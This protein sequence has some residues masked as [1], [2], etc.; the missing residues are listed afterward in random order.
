MLLLPNIDPVVD[1]KEAVE[2]I[3][4]S[5][6]AEATFLPRKALIVGET[7]FAPMV[8]YMKE[9][10]I[11]VKL[12]GI[13]PRAEPKVKALVLTFDPATGR[14]KALINGTQLTAWRTAAASGVAVLAMRV[15]P[16]TVGIIGAGLQGEYHL[17]V[18]KALYPGA[19]FKIYSRTAEKA[20]SL[21]AKYGVSVASLGETLQSDLVV[22]ATNS[23]EPV[24]KGAA[25][26]RGAAVVSVGA[27]RPV[28]EIDD[29]AKSRA[30]VVLVD[31][32]HAA[33][34]SDDVGPRWLYIGDY[35][36]GAPWEPG[37]LKIYKSVGSPLFDAAMAKYVMEKTIK[38]GLG[39]EIVWD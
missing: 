33:E 25:L 15:Q 17:R 4:N 21:A 38:L 13:Y 26:R 16:S 3:R 20:K 31:N 2:A 35:L 37:E 27:P 1:P 23:A 14:P 36:K 18:L 8:A 24:V 34:E 29:E 7:W 28:R 10:G 30:G 32:P 12:V 39:L 22:A 9:A 19:H 5:F 6:F 11:A